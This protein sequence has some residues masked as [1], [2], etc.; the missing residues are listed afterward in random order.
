MDYI[1]I[2]TGIQLYLLEISGPKVPYWSPPKGGFTG[3]YSS[4]RDQGLLLFAENE[5]A[6]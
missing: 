3:E 1:I 5:P 6:E 4:Y 2:S